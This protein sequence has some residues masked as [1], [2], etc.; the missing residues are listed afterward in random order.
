[1]LYQ[2]LTL[3]LGYNAALVTIGAMLLGAALGGRA[4]L[5]IGED[6][7]LDPLNQWHEPELALPVESRS[8]PIAVAIEYRVRRPDQSSPLHWADPRPVVSSA[9]IMKP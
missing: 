2:A 5:S 8:G 1:M 6:T 9:P 4:R 7:N 3:Q